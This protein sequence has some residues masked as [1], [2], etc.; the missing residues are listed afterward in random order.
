MFATQIPMQPGGL[1]AYWDHV[2]PADWAEVLATFPLFS[3]IPNRRL[4]RLVRRATFAQ[5]GPGDVVVEKGA[6][7]DSLYVI[8]SG[9]ARARGKPAARTLRTGDYFGE[10]GLLD[11]VPRSA[12]VVATSE[13]HV[14]RLPG[15]SFLR[16]AQDN[17]SVSLKM[18]SNVGR[19][20]RRLETRAAEL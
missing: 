7:G 14:M 18:L 1:M 8:L 11:S 13:L 6:P 9:S 19:Q 15:A 20:V 17:P 12:T 16:L 10:L 3:G 5:Y 2:T 4:R